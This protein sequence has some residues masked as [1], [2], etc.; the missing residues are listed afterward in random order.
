MTKMSKAPTPPQRSIPDVAP[1][2]ARWTLG[3]PVAAELEALSAEEKRRRVRGL[4]ERVVVEG[5][6]AYAVCALTGRKDLL[7]VRYRYSAS[8]ASWE[9]DRRVDHASSA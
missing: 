3:G 2:R 7:D 4:V 1:G 6:A 5:S 8:G 9:T